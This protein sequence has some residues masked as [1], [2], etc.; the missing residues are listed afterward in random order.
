MRG[1]KTWKMDSSHKLQLPARPERHGMASSKEWTHPREYNTLHRRCGSGR[2]CFHHRP[3]RLHRDHFIINC[4]RVELRNRL[5]IGLVW[6][7][8]KTMFPSRC[9]NES[10]RCR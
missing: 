10:F 3:H 6:N 5:D 9:R 2:C 4:L 7:N 1:R 8:S